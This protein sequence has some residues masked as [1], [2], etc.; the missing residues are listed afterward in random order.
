MRISLNILF[1]IEI[2]SIKQL[3]AHA[4]IFHAKHNLGLI[5][6]RRLMTQ[7]EQVVIAT[8]LSHR[9]EDGRVYLQDRGDRRYLK[10]AVRIG[11]VTRDGF[12][13][14]AGMEFLQHFSQQKSP[15]P[16]PK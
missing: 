3:Y 5:F 2:I 8:L 13:T 7:L 6:Y 1:L 16:T 12:I 11:F 15:H 4:G 14:P 9:F 10:Q